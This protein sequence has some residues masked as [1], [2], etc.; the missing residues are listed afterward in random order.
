MRSRLLRDILGS[1][2]GGP[3]GRRKGELGHKLADY[4]RFEDLLMRLLD[5]D[6]L[7]RMKP[8]EALQHEFLRKVPTVVTGVGGES[9]TSPTRSLGRMLHART[10]PST[11]L[12]TSLE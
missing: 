11:L 6:P 1:A 10:H 5:L 9:S 4:E 12:H 7:T 8:H 3:G 2:T